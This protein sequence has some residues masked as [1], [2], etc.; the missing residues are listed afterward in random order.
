MGEDYFFYLQ[1][2]GDYTLSANVTGKDSSDGIIL[3]AHGNNLYSVKAIRP[4]KYTLTAE[5][6]VKATNE[7][8]AG[9]FN[10]TVNKGVVNFPT[11]PYEVAHRH[12]NGYDPASGHDMTAYTLEGL[13]REFKDRSHISSVAVTPVIDPEWGA[14]YQWNDDK[15]SANHSY[16]HG[17]WLGNSPKASAT[18][19]LRGAFNENDDFVMHA[20]VAGRYNVTV[21]TKPGYYTKDTHS[22]TVLVDPVVEGSIEFSIPFQ[23]DD[24]N[25]TIILDRD[26]DWSSVEVFTGHWGD[27]YY[28][29]EKD[30]PAPVM[31]VTSEDQTAGMTEARYSRVNLTDAKS[32]TVQQKVNG[33]VTPVLTYALDPGNLTGIDSVDSEEAEAL[34]FTLQGVQ[35]DRRPT[36]KGIYIRVINGKSEKY[37]VR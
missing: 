22:F 15:H 34:Y 8:A 24:A 35:L 25:Q 5:G 28:S 16:Y 36:D 37:Y 18:E 12:N 9:S 26:S 23:Y 2:E 21:R 31:R 3:T 27:I 14:K 6:T 17:L 33:L 7:P 19:K 29:V 10:L 13:A 32:L 1:P 4:E 20:N 30:S 11:E